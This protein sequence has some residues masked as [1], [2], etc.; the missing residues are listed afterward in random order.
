MDLNKPTDRQ[1]S[2]TINPDPA[3]HG[4]AMELMRGSS[5]Q[6]P[7]GALDDGFNIVDSTVDVQSQQSAEKTSAADRVEDHYDPEKASEICKILDKMNL[8][9]DH[10]QM[11]VV[12]GDGWNSDT[13]TM[14]LLDRVN[15][16][17]EPTGQH[18][19][20]DVGQK[21]LGWGRGL[22]EN[23][24][25]LGVQK[26]E[27]DMKAPAG[28]FQI[29]T[30]FGA[31]GQAPAGTKMPYKHVG[32]ND[33][34]IDDT[35]SADYNHWETLPEGDNRPDAHWKSFER[36][37]RPDGKYDLGFVVDH[38]MDPAIAGDGSAIFL[39]LWKQPGSG[40]A[41]C[42]SMSEDSMR[43]LMGWLDPTQKPLLLQVPSDS[44]EELRE[45]K[46][47]AGQ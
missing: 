47:K 37:Q 36:M 46:L 12:T 4:Q 25:D 34:F 18:W 27:G 11:V 17:W 28:I 31:G 33:Y 6:G 38:N 15:G 3:L 10:K 7:T 13:G 22:I 9:P 24:E 45:A 26:H 8:S 23:S 41:G 20:V 32:D 21:G 43:T 19:A 35:T 29:G 44:I 40:T 16:H 39:H 1:E 30:A 42:T 5:G 2:S 14:Q